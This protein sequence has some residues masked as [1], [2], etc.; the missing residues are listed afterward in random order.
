MLSAV[1]E[2]LKSPATRPEFVLPVSCVLEQELSQSL[3]LNE[4]H[5]SRTVCGGFLS[6]AGAFEVGVLFD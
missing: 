4:R 3:G 1:Q 6:Q 2:E 5:Q